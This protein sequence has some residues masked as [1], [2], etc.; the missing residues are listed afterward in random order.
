[1]SCTLC[2]NVGPDDFIT[3]PDDF[4]S[5]EI[6]VVLQNAQNIYRGDDYHSTCSH[7]DD[8]SS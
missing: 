2:H 5:D 4:S 8:S 3:K 1:M 7:S 6:H